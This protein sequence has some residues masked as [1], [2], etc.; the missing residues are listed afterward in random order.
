MQGADGVSDTALINR[1]AVIRL[2][3]N[4]VQAAALRRWQ[5]G[6]RFVWNA[7]WAWCKTQRETAGK[8]PSKAAI[9]ARMV[10]MKKEAGTE[11][12]AEI[13][14]HAILALADDLARA[15]RNWF[16]KRAKMPK[17]RGKHQRAFSVY[18][19]NQATKFGEQLVK[20]P[21]LGDVR[22]KAGGL[23]EGRLLSS[24]IYRDAD[25]WFMSAVFECLAPACV[26]PR[27]E[28][29]G[30]DMGLITLA[31]VFDG[32]TVHTFDNVKA[33]REHEARLRRYQRRVS[34]RV[35]GSKRRER[36]KQ[37][38]ARLHQRI[39]N[40]RRDNAHKATSQIVAM[41]D[42]IVVESLN[43][44]GMLKTRHLSKS[45]SDASM[46]MFLGM[47]R[48][49][50]AW[51]GRA[52]IEADRWFPSSK[53]CSAC[54]EVH[55]MPLAARTMRCGC[56]NTMNRDE[57]AARNLF[58][59]S[60]EPRNA[61]GKTPETRAEIGGQGAAATPVPVPVGEARMSKQA[62]HVECVV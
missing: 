7:T 20:L 42:T 33:L 10:A 12:I 59:Y 1:A 30:I 13:P 19:V 29:V 44:R 60:E 8:W 43:V 36:A 35:K 47:L 26:A 4:Q 24:R 39:T 46:S 28:R 9:Q 11:W 14:A 55:E 37:A 52:I 53:T 25:K 50:A 62:T 56:G 23:P 2:Y 41:A 32:Q 58:A 21:K 18:A 5:G 61:G 38:V 49:K 3:P 27:V 51:Q 16:E 31:T 48:Y 22:F 6:L 34:R 15:M 17:F 45:V 54:G 40:I 57:N